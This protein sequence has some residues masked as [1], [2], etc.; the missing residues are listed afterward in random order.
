MSEPPPRLRRSLGLLE[1]T[2][3]G[4]GV[5]L[6]AGIYALI[7]AVAAEAGNGLWLSFVLSAA[8]AMI[9]G[10]CYAELASMFP[11]AGADYVYS[12]HALGARLAFLVGWLIIAGNIIAASAVALSFGGYLAEFMAIDRTTAALLALVVASLVV[13]WGVRETLWFSV[14]GTLVEVG[15]LIAV[16]VIGVPHLGNFEF[17]EFNQGATGVLQGAALVMFAFLGFSEIATLAEEAEDASNVVPRAMVLALAISTLLYLTVAVSAVSILGWQELSASDAPMADVVQHVLGQRAGEVIAGVALFSTANTMLLL[18]LAASRLIYGMAQARA[19]P[20]FLGWVHPK[21][22]TPVN[23]ILLV[24]LTGAGFAL[25][26]RL[27]L[28]AGATN[29]ALFIGF[30]AACVSV[31]VLRFRVPDL[32]R[33]LKVPGSLG[34]LPVLPVAGVLLTVVLI[35]S[36]E[37][38]VILAGCGLLLSGSIAFLLTSLGGV[39]KVQ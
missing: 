24:L 26:G 34:R 38:D 30:A 17:T 14:L 23:A 31:V 2:L 6:G 9:V 21:M 22:R 20:G 33:L 12:L 11:R 18:V 25:T 36:L 10:L 19:L 5:I 27:A 1:T 37:G 32:P 4:V 29:F 15:G 35:F 16:V 13:L 8:L 39:R 28:V 7:G 3:G